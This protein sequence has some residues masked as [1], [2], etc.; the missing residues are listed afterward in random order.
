MTS[1]T[2]PIHPGAADVRG[3]GPT[4]VGGFVTIDGERYAR[5]GNVDSMPPFLMSVVS[6]SDMW[7]FVG[8]NGPSTAGRR[9]PDTAL[10]PYQTADK[11]LRDAATG[12][13]RTTILA[14]RGGAAALW[15]PWQDTV[16][17][18]RVTRN[19][20]K[21]VDGTGVLFEETNDD[22]GL[23]FRWSLSASDRFGLIRHARID[24]LA[25]QPV[26]VR[27]LDG[28]HQ[29]IPPGVDQDTFARLSYLAAAYMR[30]ELLPD[31]PLAIYTLNA[32]ISDRPEPS[33][34]LRV[35]AAW[36]V[37][38][39][40]PTIF[41]DDTHVADFR[42]GSVMRGDTEVRGEF[43][44]YL[45]ADGV[46]LG[47]R[48]GHEWY[49]VGDT[50]LDHAALLEIRQLLRTP[51]AARAA[52]QEA[53][54]EDRTG[55][56][57]RVAGA[58]GLQLTADE[59]VTANHF[60]NV[61]FNIMRGGSF[62]HAYEVPL[63]DLASYLDDQ[64]R[65]VCAR[66]RAWIEELP[67][68][69]QLRDLVRA[70]AERGDPQLLRL[71]RS[72]LPLTFSRRHGDPSR[73]WNRFSIRVRDRAGAPVYGYEGNWRDI[74]QNWDALG[75][76]YPGYV[77]QFIAVFLNA[78]TA[79]GYN[80][81]RIT[82]QGIDWEVD[83]PRDPWSHIGYW[84]DHQIVYLQRL[85]DACERH[86]PG[87]LKAGL[88]ERI[89]AYAD[90]PYRIADFATILADPRHTIVFDRSRHEA[91]V[92]A[93]RDLGAD[94]SL[95]RDE[96]GEVRLVTLG[97]KLLVPLLV[98][99]TNLVPDSGIWLNTQRPEWNDANNALAGWGLSLVTLSAISRYLD[100]LSALFDGDGTVALSPVV[101]RL[102]EGVTGILDEID[103]P[104][105]DATRFVIMG[106]LGRVGEQ[107]RRALD[108]GFGGDLVVTAP[109]SVRRLIAAASR[110][111]RAT[112]RAGR[113]PDG[114]YHSYDL[115][116]VTGERAAVDHLGPM[117]E[118]QVAVLESRLLDDAEA[119]ALLRAL[120]DSDLYR[121]DQ[122]SYL[123]YPDRRIGS[124]LE[125]NTLQGEPP[126]A[127]PSLFV[128]DRSGAWHFQ[129]DLSTLAD[130]ERRLE[131]A[132]AP[133]ST[134]MAVR[135]LWRSTFAHD[136]FTGRS[137]RF[138]MFEGLGSIYWHMIAKL[139]LAV[140]GCHRRA[141]DPRAEAEL[142]EHYHDIRDGLGFRKIPEVYG[143]FPT[144]PYSHSPRHRGAQQPGMTGQ[145][146]EQVLTRFGELGVEVAEGRLR[147]EPKLLR[148]A[149]FGGP[150]TE[151]AYLDASGL[152]A[153][154][155]LT[156]GSLAFT[157]AQ[158]PIIYRLGTVPAIELERVDGLTE[159][160]GGSTLGPDASAEIFAR[161]GTYRRLTV[162]VRPESLSQA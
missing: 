110:V 161:S 55:V 98:K 21:R 9:S 75:Q 46:D 62:E 64:D 139:L 53:I 106:R 8:S 73:P 78:S 14:T 84:G 51:G 70:T 160:V 122:N 16:G 136:A 109:A 131:A 133:A 19:L 140:Q 152:E 25:G 6:D 34:S 85:L 4:V 107:H 135:D 124:F 114:L 13:A 7:L 83:D 1:L 24:E 154:C 32:A 43:G 112:I 130:V 54:A 120:R 36:S 39:P 116:R 103:G 153:S 20:Y 44:A 117:L 67:E 101:A 33:E 143:A 118:G 142:A 76:S 74:F 30:H 94:G 47:P 91:L 17:S 65:P 134:R 95:L 45:V 89:Y 87:V 100:F 50:S 159:I 123:L 127:D 72:Y 11:I 35:A 141:T 150:A 82:R 69:M 146:K 12:G 90:V 31:V 149:E 111:V 26:E 144:D 128:A 42:R 79:D 96:R 156:A 40:H 155:S 57:R 66:H 48:D 151:F 86:E 5:I 158:V 49:T 68:G 56:R 23:R 137:A 18:W 71:V 3:P 121:A 125:R 28:W 145:V 148:A 81:Y 119:I 29:V 22:L 2:P 99:L 113:R 115:L 129:A 92:A 97:E 138:F 147:L 63:D 10:F 38:H 88:G 15:E 93:R 58:D 41:L 80:P 132:G 61:L 27:Y 104:V 162:T 105:D 59:A 52:L 77:P 102:L 108:A 157:Y 37:G 60:A 126:I